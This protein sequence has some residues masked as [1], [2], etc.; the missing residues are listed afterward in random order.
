MMIRQEMILAKSGDESNMNEM[1]DGYRTCSGECGKT[2]PL[3]EFYWRQDSNKH[4]NE[5]KSCFGKMVEARTDKSD[6]TK[7]NHK[8]YVKNHDAILKQKKE[9]NIAHKK[10]ARAYRI[11]NRK[12][13]NKQ[14]D[15]W[16]KNHP[17][18]RKAKAKRRWERNKVAIMKRAQE[19]I[20]STPSLKIPRLLRDRLKKAIRG[21]YKAG[22]AIKDLGCSIVFLKERFESLFEAHPITGEQ[23][24]WENYGIRWHIDHIIPLSY[25]NLSDHQ[26]IKVACNYKNLRPLWIEDNLKKSDSLPENIN[27]LMTEIKEGINKTVDIL[28][29]ECII[30]TEDNKS[31]KQTSQS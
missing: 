9:Y 26:Q 17:E 7:Y 29:E 24:G 30:T 2:K 1:L 12:R 8:Y 21:G 14:S 19:R 18:K 3:N 27:E 5:C 4:R 31:S 13:L 23:M 16:Y 22:S 20:N 11:K 28:Q 25:F 10:E 6:K 15:L